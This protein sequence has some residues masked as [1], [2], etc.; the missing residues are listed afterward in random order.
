[1]ARGETMEHLESGCIR[2]DGSRIEVSATISPLKNSVGKVT[3]A[4]RIA[5]D[6]TETKRMETLANGQRRIL[7]MIASDAPLKETLDALLGIV[8]AQVTEMYCSILLLDAEGVRLWHC[9][10]PR[11]P[12]DYTKAI[13]GTIIGPSVGSCGTAAFRGKPVFVEDIASDPLWENYKAIAMAHGLRACWSTP[14]FDAQQK[15]LG[16]FAIYHHSTGL[17]RIRDVELIDLAT[18]TAAIAISRQRAKIA[19][20]EAEGQLRQMQKMEGIGQLAGGVA[21]DFN[22]IL[23]SLMM[24]TELTE[25]VEKLPTEAR[26]GLRQIRADAQRAAELTRQLLLF[27]R[28]QVMQV[29]LLDLNER[30]ITLSKMLQRIIGEDVELELDLHSGKLMVNAD[31]GMIDQVLMNLAV[32]AR[33]AMPGG[34]CL[35]IRTGLATVDKNGKDLAPDSAPGRYVCVSVTD[36]GKGI[37]PEILPQIFEPF[38]TTKDV[39]KGTGLGLA[40]VF[41]IVKQHQGWIKVDSRPGQGA[42]FH[43]YL[44]ICASTVSKPA[45]TEAKPKTHRGTETVLMVSSEVALLKQMRKLL[46]QHDYTVLEATSASEAQTRWKESRGAVSLLLT[47]LVISGGTNGRELAQLLQ[48]E[49]PGMKVIFAGDSSTEIDGLEFQLRN[50][51]PFIQ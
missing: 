23:T 34:G 46:E 1:M 36:T 42:T 29:R 18:H 26:D 48:T 17:P 9:S 20:Q 6:I 21:H 2:K 3:G 45:P 12:A 22:N 28:R 38:F 5:H 47:D 24:Q 31:A 41:G 27:S 43:V 14:I 40:T 4:S 25:M 39:G 19:L 51:E 16:T 32:N 44:P 7:E 15:I 13:D 8:E 50:G 30:V 49:Q 35:L 33:D 10:A 37:P 11:L